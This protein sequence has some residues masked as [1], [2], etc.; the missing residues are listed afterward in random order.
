[1]HQVAHLGVRE[2]THAQEGVEEQDAG[3]VFVLEAFQ[4][5]ERL[6]LLGVQVTLGLPLVRRPLDRASRVLR[7]HPVLYEVIAEGA[8]MREPRV[9]RAGPDPARQLGHRPPMDRVLLNAPR[10]GALV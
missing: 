9:D 5:Q 3:D 10:R 2:F 7:E 4:G 1:V 6:Q 8:Q